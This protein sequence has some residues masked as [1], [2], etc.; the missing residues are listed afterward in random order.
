[1]KKIKILLV[2]SFLSMLVQPVVAGVRIHCKE[3]STIALHLIEVA[4]AAGDD[5]GSRV[6]A[7]A[8]SLAGTQ[9]A[10]ASDNDSIGTI[11]V[12][13]HGF[14]RMDL[15]NYALA[16]A[17]ASRKSVPSFK[18]FEKALESVSRRKGEDSGFPSRLYYSSEW[19]VD[20]IYRGNLKEMTEYLTG[21][22]FKTKTLDYVSRHKDEFPALKDPETMD[23][24]KLNEMG[25]RS[26]R[27]PHLKKQSIGNKE[28]AELMQTGDIIIMLPHDMDYDIYDLGVIEMKDGVPYMI[29]FSPQSGKVQEDE[30]P[31]T[32]LFKLEGQ[33]FY[34]YRWLRP[35][36]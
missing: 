18:E 19:I 10:P 13:L 32:R 5:F 1:M 23:K 22:G 2:L 17:I 12:N 27:I 35:T 3:D 15:V 4:S 33:H 29:H 21:G 14:D 36:E 34:G 24:V 26:H 9:W 28:I 16:A 6:A 7:A 30:Y 20:N 11:M 25:Y 8:K 31:L